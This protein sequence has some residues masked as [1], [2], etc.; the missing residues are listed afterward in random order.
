MGT[1]RLGRFIPPKKGL[2]FIGPQCIMFVRFEAFTV[3]NMKYAVFG[4]V[5]QCGSP[6]SRPYYVSPK[7]RFI[8]ETQRCNFRKG[9]IFISM[10]V[11][12]KTHMFT[13]TITR[14]KLFMFWERY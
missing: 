1:E 9:R 14:N 13:A 8:K 4:D 11:F 3:V 2:A 12:R 7:R 6:M 10:S 5:P